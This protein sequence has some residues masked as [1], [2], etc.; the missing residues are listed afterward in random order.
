M[1]FISVPFLTPGAVL[2][3]PFLIKQPPA[4]TTQLLMTRLWFCREVF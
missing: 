3:E 4:H 1:H 2:N